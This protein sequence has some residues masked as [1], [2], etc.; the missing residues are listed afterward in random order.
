MRNK[1]EILC[2]LLVIFLFSMRGYSQYMEMDIEGDE[3]DF[4]FHLKA[5]VPQTPP[6]PPPPHVII[7]EPLSPPPP[8]PPPPPPAPPQV[9]IVQP[10]P[11]PP[12]PPSPPKV[13]VVQRA[14]PVVVE[15]RKALITTPTKYTRGK[16][17]GIGVRGIYVI[18]GDIGM[19][20]GGVG[21]SLKYDFNHR[22]GIEFIGE[23]IKGKGYHNVLYGNVE[24]EEFALGINGVGYGNP[25]HHLVSYGLLGLGFSIA[26]IEHNK[27]D[28]PVYFHFGL[29]LGLEVRLLRF[30][31]ISFDIR[32]M[33]RARLNE[34]KD[35]GREAMEAGNG[36]CRFSDSGMIECT[37]WELGATLNL[38]LNFFWF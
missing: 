25:Q 37:R 9:I 35:G 26:K 32:G 2:L 21:L 36:S 13:V 10:S 16:A 15:Q 27:L 33:I 17:F 11:P 14:K 24:R 5:G 28:I 18:P 6:P 19:Q 7:E 1:V 20:L 4:E 12:P 34:F 30:L 8:P 38:G 31:S 3:D 23:Y 29:G 22:D